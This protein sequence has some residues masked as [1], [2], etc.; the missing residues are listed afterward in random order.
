MMKQ[1]KALA[2]LDLI[3]ETISEEFK[4]KLKADIKQTYLTLSAQAKEQGGE[5]M[6][7]KL[8]IDRIDEHLDLFKERE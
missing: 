7:L 6:K 5:R 2:A 8:G 3:Y 1:I 4:D